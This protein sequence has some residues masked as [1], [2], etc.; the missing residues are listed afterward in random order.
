[1]KSISNEKTNL[2]EAMGAV[3]VFV[4][5]IIVLELLWIVTG[6]NPGTK[7]TDYL[8]S[9]RQARLCQIRL[10]SVHPDSYYSDSVKAF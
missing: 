1:M 2:R 4:I 5:L 6:K 3:P 8:G 9:L 7:L 10:C